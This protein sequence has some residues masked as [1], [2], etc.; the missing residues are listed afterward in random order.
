[1]LTLNVAGTESL[2]Y[3]PLGDLVNLWSD[4]GGGF[5]VHNWNDYRFKDLYQVDWSKSYVQVIGIPAGTPF[6]YIFK[7]S[8]AYGQDVD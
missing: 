8:Y 7:V 6:S 4:T 5:T 3:I 1:V 2:Q